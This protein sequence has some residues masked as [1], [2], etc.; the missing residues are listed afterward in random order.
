MIKLSCKSRENNRNRKNHGSN[1]LKEVKKCCTGI[2][3][4]IKLV[5]ILNIKNICCKTEDKKNKTIIFS[6]RLVKR[7]LQT[8]KVLGKTA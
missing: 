1:E 4:N 2:K 7:G 6:F 8:L 3:R 5:F